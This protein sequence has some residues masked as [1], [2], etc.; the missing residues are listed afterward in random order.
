MIKKFKDKGLKLFFEHNN[1]KGIQVKHKEKIR[2]IL[3]LLNA[4][5]KPE[6][7]N[8]PGFGFHELLGNRKGTYSVTVAKNWR[9]TFKFDG[10]NAYDVDYEDYH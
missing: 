1:H 5:N 4:T 8:I 9:I 10:G 6:G 2:D 3:T 7:M